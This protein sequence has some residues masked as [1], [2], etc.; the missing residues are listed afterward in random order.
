MKPNWLA[1]LGDGIAKIIGFTLCISLTFPTFAQTGLIN[2]SPAITVN[3]TVG[4]L[5]KGV[6]VLVRLPLQGLPITRMYTQREYGHTYLYIEHGWQSLT[7]VD[8]TKKRNPRLV[9][10]EPAKVEPITYIELFDGGAVEAPSLR[11]VYAG[12]DNQG[13]GTMFNTLQSSDSSDDKLLEAFGQG[14]SNLVDRDSGLVYFASPSQMSI[15]KDNRW[16]RI[17]LPN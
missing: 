12:I 6:K 8:V 14:T 15:V 17:D 13:S 4:Q 3:P 16:R 1:A 9:D 7:T 5:P 2:M 11:H 10:H